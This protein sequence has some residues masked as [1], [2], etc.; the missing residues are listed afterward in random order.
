[1]NHSYDIIILGAGGA[2][3]MCAGLAGQLGKQVLVLDHAKKPAEKVRISGGGRC[4]FTNVNTAHDRLLSQNPQFARNALAAYKPT[5]FIALIES[6]SIAYHEKTLGQL[7][8]DGSSQQVV[9]MLLAECT[10]GKVDIKLQTEIGRISFKD[11]LYLVE[12][13]NGAATAPKLVVATGGKSI[14]NMGAT[15][16]GYQIA[17]QFGLKLIEQRAGLVPFTLS[18]EMKE[19]YATLSGVAVDAVV[20]AG[21]KSFSE[22][23]LFTHRGLS[24]PAVL[25]ASSYWHEGELIDI[26]LAPDTDVY[27]VLLSARTEHPKAELGTHLAGVLP[28]RLAALLSAPYAGRSRMADLSN[29]TLREIADAIHHWQLTPNG[30]EGYRTAEVTVGGVDTADLSPKTMEAKPQPGLYFIGEVVDVTGWLGGYNFQWAWSSAAA[31][32]RSF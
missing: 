28:K 4:N 31:A 18:P 23:M 20:T 15:G 29:K 13:N 5:D 30:T 1:M 27:A 11:G 12:T 14:P 21:G 7:F 22:A 8:C 25:Q 10:K 32:A 2:G 26:N 17:T 3:L 24:G 9:D 19:Q 6:Y 16:F